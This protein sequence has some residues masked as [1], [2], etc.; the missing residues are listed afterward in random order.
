MI[1]I[2]QGNVLNASENLICHQVNCKGVMGAGLAKQIK[3][4]YPEVFRAYQELCNQQGSKLLGKAYVVK[5][6]V[7]IFGQNEYGT[8]SRKTDY[9][10]LEK[11]FKALHKNLPSKISLAFPYNFGCGL[12]GGDWNTVYHL[13][14][15]CFE[16]REIKI[17]KL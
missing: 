2:V 1:Q 6:I 5:R 4:R 15:Q 3:I 8:S 13:I 11:A 12:A 16:N 17:Y 7:N 10:A 9:K 14:E